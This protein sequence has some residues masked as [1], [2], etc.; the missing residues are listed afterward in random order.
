M[1]LVRS[2]SESA[3]LTKGKYFVYVPENCSFVSGRAIT[4]SGFYLKGSYVL[5][6]VKRTADATTLIAT[7]ASATSPLVSGQCRRNALVTVSLYDLGGAAEEPWMEAGPAT[8][9]DTM[10][11]AEAGTLTAVVHNYAGGLAVASSDNL[12]VLNAGDGGLFADNGD[13]TATL[14]LRYG[15]VAEGDGTGTISVM[16]DG[17]AIRGGAVTVRTKAPKLKFDETVYRLTNS[18]RSRGVSLTYR[19]GDGSAYGSY[20]QAL[21]DELLDVRTEVSGKAESLVKFKPTL[22]SLK[23]NVTID[24]S[25]AGEYEDAL[26]ARPASPGCGVAA[27]KAGVDLAL[28]KGSASDWVIDSEAYV[29]QRKSFSF[30]IA[31]YS[32]GMTVSCSDNLELSAG[33]TKNPDGSATVRGTYGCL[34]KG[35]GAITVKLNGSAIGNGSRGVNVI[36]PALVISPDPIVI[37]GS[38]SSF[39]FDMHYED[40]DGNR[41]TDFD[42][43][44][45]DELIV[46]GAYFEERAFR[47][48]EQEMEFYSMQ[49]SLSGNTLSWGQAGTSA[50]YEGVLC[51]EPIKLDSGVEAAWADIE[52]VDGG[53]GEVITNGPFEVS[54]AYALARTGSVTGGGSTV[55]VYDYTLSYAIT[56]KGTVPSSLTYSVKSSGSYPVSVQDEPDSYQSYDDDIPLRTTSVTITGSSPNKSFTEHIYDYNRLGDIAY[57]LDVVCNGRTYS[58]DLT[59][60]PSL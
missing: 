25:S 14:S 20:D 28:P 59:E 18:A 10:Y 42:E 57:R 5:D 26:V 17:S 34:R 48:Q 24:E 52:V 2:S 31:G 50:Y 12:R 7:G 33:V 56:Y 27:A 21:Y 58:F 29:A 13:G 23:D 16:K 32:D 54:Y 41:M 55:A 22:V 9:R 4:P 11:V 39:T 6:G 35:A 53:A 30:K 60:T 37:S 47:D 46:P 43:A 36:A 45:Y 44:L 1:I 8:P 19:L 38:H 15:C 40:K 51:A 3:E 49:P